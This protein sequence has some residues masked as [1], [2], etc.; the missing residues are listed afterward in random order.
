[1]AVPKRK[2]SRSKQGMRAAHRALEPRQFNKNTDGVFLTPHIAEKRED[3]YYYKGICI[4]RFK[5][6][7]KNKAEES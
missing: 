5:I 4:K 3:G 2:T 1:M 6:R 7:D